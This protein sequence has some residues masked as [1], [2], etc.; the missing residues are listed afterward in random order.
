VALPSEQALV[1]ATS[2]VFKIQDWQASMWSP[3]ANCIASTS[4][5]RHEWDDLD[6]FVASAG[7]GARGNW[8]ADW[9]SSEGRRMQFARGPRVS[10]R[11]PSPPARLDLISPCQ[12]AEV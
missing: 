4:I 3:T 8:L 7:R 10:S 1:D 12:R 9:T 5:T 11:D 6:Y 2:V